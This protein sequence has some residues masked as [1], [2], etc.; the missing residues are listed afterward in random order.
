MPNFNLSE[1]NNKL[2]ADEVQ[3]QLLKAQEIANTL[4]DN[5]NIQAHLTNLFYN[6]S[7]FELFVA[8]K[9]DH[10]WNSETQGIDATS[11]NSTLYYEYKTVK[12]KGDYK[13]LSFQFHWLSQTK[14]DQYQNI[15]KFYLI[16]R[17]VLEID[18]II[19]VDPKFI[20]DKNSTLINKI[21]SQKTGSKSKKAG[22]KSKKAGSKKSGGHFSITAGSFLDKV[23]NNIPLNENISNFKFMFISQNIQFNGQQLNSDDLNKEVKTTQELEIRKKQIRELKRIYG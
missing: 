17:E 15:H 3:K 21:Q 4:T 23:E 11:T 16:W 22:S 20:I 8:K 18:M 7:F 12:K 1:S 19:E 2:I 9:L 13:G 10:I 14:V 5:Q 6:E